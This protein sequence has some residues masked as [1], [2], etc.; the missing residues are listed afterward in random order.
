MK[1]L[2]WGLLAT[3]LTA[4]AHVLLHRLS[5]RGRYG[6]LLAIWVCALAVTL[7]AFAVAGAL[8]PDLAG[9]LP[10]TTTEYA[11][12]VVLYA[13]LS[14]AYITTYPP[15]QADSPSMSLVLR[16]AEAGPRGLDPRV[17]ESE[18]TDAE[19]I[20]PRLND[21]VNGELVHQR[22]ERYV[23]SR[24]ASTLARAYLGYRRALRMEKGG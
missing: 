10:A 9:W 5:P 17:L 20:L 21:L 16:I 4:V 19:L 6:A 24:R 13:T 18:F 2:V 7:G 12:F 15:I 8:R 11:S 14:L 23:A 1:P 22:G 3:V